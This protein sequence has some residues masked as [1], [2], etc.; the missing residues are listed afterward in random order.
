MRTLLATVAALALFGGSAFAVE[1]PT[2]TQ[3][4]QS[5]DATA[6]PIQHRSQPMHRIE[7]HLQY[8]TPAEIAQTQRLNEEALRRATGGNPN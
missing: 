7:R 6:P 2:A 3:T 5:D 4:A 8:S 1:P